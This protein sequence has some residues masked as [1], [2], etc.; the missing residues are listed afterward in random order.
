[1]A[2]V[3]CTYLDMGIWAGGWSTVFSRDGKSSVYLPG[4]GLEDGVLCSRAARTI[5]DL[6]DPK[7]G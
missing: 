2:K 4:Y 6:E 7:A 5:S 1:M 3:V